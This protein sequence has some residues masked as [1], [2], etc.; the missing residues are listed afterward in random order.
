MNTRLT[1][2]QKN[3]VE[4]NH[5][6]IYGFAKLHKIDV[7]EH[8]DV[9]AI[10]LCKAAIAYDADK[11]KFSTYAYQ[12][13]K[14]EISGETVRAKRRNDILM[15]AQKG[16]RERTEDIDYDE[17]PMRDFINQ[18]QGLKKQVVLLGMRGLTL[19]EIAERTGE[20]RNKISKTKEYLQ[21]IWKIFTNI[22]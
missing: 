11:S 22:R 18:L 10:G 20:T 14:G 6:L 21:C 2:N 15:K 5:N 12:K 13:M 8:Y 7:N 3:L 17:I 9:L 19:D 4:E 1:S 16:F